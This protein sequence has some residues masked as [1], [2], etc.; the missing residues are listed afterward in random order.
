M[1]TQ[2]QFEDL[3]TA[4]LND[5][6]DNMEALLS[7]CAGAERQLLMSRHSALRDIFWKAKASQLKDFNATVEELCG[8]L[9]VE[10]KALKQALAD[11]KAV[12][13]VI[14]TLT[15]VI[16]LAGAVVTAAAV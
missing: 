10:T 8:Q 16:K 6:D 7:R 9:A 12:A 1:T 4:T 11:L 13:A 3:L 2:A 14:Q 5:V 15:E